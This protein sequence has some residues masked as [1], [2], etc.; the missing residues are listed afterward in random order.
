[1][2]LYT[3]LRGARQFIEN[4]KP[5]L[6]HFCFAI[7]DFKRRQ[8]WTSLTGRDWRP[9]GTDRTYFPDQDEIEV[10]VS[11]GRGIWTKG[12]AGQTRTVL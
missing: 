6:D 4:Q 10:Q 9:I 3:A 1:V 11:P 12:L 8:S 2:R 5:G 7:E